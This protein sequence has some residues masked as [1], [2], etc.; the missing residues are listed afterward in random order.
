MSLKFLF[1]NVYALHRPGI[2]GQLPHHVPTLLNRRIAQIIFLALVG[3]RRF[4]LDL[5]VG[6]A[7][8]VIVPFSGCTQSEI[9]YRQPLLTIRD[10]LVKRRRP[11]AGIQSKLAPPRVAFVFSDNTW[12]SERQARITQITQHVA[13]T[14]NKRRDVISPDVGGRS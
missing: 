13:I 3:Q 6:I 12:R 10:R 2:D 5:S 11:S 7:H 1:S 9:R 14:P 4:A 8:Y